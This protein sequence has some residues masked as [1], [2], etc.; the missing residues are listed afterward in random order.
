MIEGFRVGYGFLMR[1]S[2]VLFVRLFVVGIEAIARAESSDSRAE[3]ALAA[4][5]QPLRPLLLEF[6]LPG[7]EIVRYSYWNGSV[8]L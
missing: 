2:F 1:L 6:P 3:A 5:A 8:V 4:A 7:P